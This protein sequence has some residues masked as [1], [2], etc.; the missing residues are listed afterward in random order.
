MHQGFSLAR[1]GWHVDVKI[2]GNAAETPAASNAA[3]G[4][5]KAAIVALAKAFTDR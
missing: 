1:R 2:A 3:V 4:V 5:I